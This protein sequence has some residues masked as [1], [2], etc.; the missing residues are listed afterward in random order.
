KNDNKLSFYKFFKHGQA[1]RAINKYSNP[2][3]IGS[4]TTPR[5]N[6]A[7]N[8]RPLPEAIKPSNNASPIQSRINGINKFPYE[9][10]IINDKK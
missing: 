10:I 9:K 3:S 2:A 4:I 7:Q 6:Q 8:E 5:T 1:S